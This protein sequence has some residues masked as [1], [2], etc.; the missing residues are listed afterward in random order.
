VE[1]GI[2]ERMAKGVIAGYPVVDVKA[3]VFDGSFHNVDSSEMAFKIAGSMAFKEAYAKAD[4]VLLEPIMNV[5]A[6]TPEEFVGAVQGDLSSRRGDITGIE[7]RGNARAIH[8]QVPLA[9][10]FGYVNGLRSLTQGRA[11][12]TMQFS[13]YARVP[14]NVARGI[15][16]S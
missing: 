10:M 9:T 7:A 15:V 2:V 8:A 1:K 16:F 12:Y 6:V 14:E 4:P 5:E 3:T 13:H 11:T